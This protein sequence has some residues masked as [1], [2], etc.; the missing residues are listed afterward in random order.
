MNR[1][2]TQRPG[3]D[4]PADIETWADRLEVSPLIARLLWRRGLTTPTEMDAFLSPGLRH[5][6]APDTLPGL[7]KAAQVL[8]DGLAKGQTF[9][10]WGDYDVDG[11]TSTALVKSFAADRG[12]S[13]LHHIP[14]RLESGYGMNLEGIEQLAAKGV[15]LLLTVDCGITSH[16]EINRANELGMTVVVSDHHLPG[17]EGPPPA[18]AVTNPRL[19]D[20][21]CPDLAGVGVTFLLMAAVN[22]LLP[23]DPVDMRAYLDLVALGTIADVVR[24]TGQNRILVKN[25]LLLVGRPQAPGHRRAQGGQRLCARRRPRCRAGGFRP[26]PAH[27]RLGPPG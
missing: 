17:D 2:W 13:A 18:A 14:N 12:L 22:R 1:I 21:P 5:L 10:V 16:A 26:G 9:C 27:Q 11:V 20:C 8:A 4:A 3:E 15:E 19:E 6:A 25:G 7:T 23:G 24:L